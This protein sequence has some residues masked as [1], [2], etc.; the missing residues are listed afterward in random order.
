MEFSVNNGPLAG[1]DGKKVT[2]RQIRD[3][4]IRETQS[5]ISISVEDTDDGTRFLVNARGAM[6][7]A[8]LVETMRREGFE[9]LVSRPTVLYKEIDGTRCEPYEQVWV[10][11]PEE[12]LGSVIENISKRKAR[13]PIW[14]TTM[15]GHRRSRSPDPRPH[16]L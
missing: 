12:F 15:L 10:E 1:Q 2:S 4:L 16:R 3:R 7:I 13:S 5:N 9:I 8:V 6:Q 11:V 14:S